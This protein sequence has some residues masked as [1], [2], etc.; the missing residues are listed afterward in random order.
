[1]LSGLPKLFDK[2]FVIG[3]LLPVILALIAVAWLCPELTL[4]KPLRSLS[5]NDDILGKATYLLLVAY[6]L[7]ILLMA[8]NTLQYRLLEGSIPP[9]SWIGPLA[10]RHEARRHALAQEYETLAARREHHPAKFAEADSARLSAVGQQLSADYPPVGMKVLPTG[11]GNVIQAF[12]AYPFVVYGA[13]SAPV[14]QRLAAVIP[15]DFASQLD[16]ARAPVNAFLNLV[17][18]LKI[19][20]LIAIVRTATD[21]P[22]PAFLEA[23]RTGQLA[24]WHVMTAAAIGAAAIVL[25]GPAYLLA[26]TSAKAW[27]EVVKAAF[28]CYLPALPKQLGYAAPTSDAARRA[29]WTEVNALVVYWQPMDPKHYKFDG[30]PGRKPPSKP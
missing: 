8:T 14:W 25:I 2:N 23:M 29:F 19:V 22:W 21:T 18:V 13:D 30:A 15:K 4:L 12:E 24:H 28:D 26:K 6:G 9:L 16:D 5:V 20:A 17:Y 7:G 3:F 1:M 27:G 10:G 11:F